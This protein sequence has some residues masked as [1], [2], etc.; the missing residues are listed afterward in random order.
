LFQA[1]HSL[2]NV[3]TAS[4][5]CSG[6][7]FDQSVSGGSGSPFRMTLTVICSFRESSGMR[8]DYIT[9]EFPESKDTKAKI[10]VLWC[11]H[12]SKKKRADLCHNTK[13]AL[14]PSSMKPGRVK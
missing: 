5:R 7:A 8:E 6:V 11:C 3:H 10:F 12:A 1:K 13:P 2:V 9:R 4:I 14:N